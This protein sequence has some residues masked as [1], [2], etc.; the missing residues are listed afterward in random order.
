M[1]YAT[2]SSKPASDKQIAFIKAL[3]AD[4]AEVM[5]AKGLTVTEYQLLTLSSLGASRF[6]DNLKKLP[7]DPGAKPGGSRKVHPGV[8]PGMYI[9]DQQ[10][11]KVIPSQKADGRLYVAVL[12]PAPEGE[13]SS[14]KAKG[15]L[16]LLYKLTPEHKMTASHASFYGEVYGR[17]CCCG[18]LLTVPESVERGVGPVCWDNYFA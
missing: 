4:R 11:I 12:T 7:R 6:I 14:F 8:T 5:K 3:I 15:N 13:S 18:K 2:T 1:T 10:V 16:H 9:M 17:C